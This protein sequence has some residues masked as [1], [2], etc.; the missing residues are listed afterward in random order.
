MHMYI[1][2]KLRNHPSIRKRISSLIHFVNISCEFK[3]Q[4][5][6]CRINPLCTVQ[7]CTCGLFCSDPSCAPVWTLG[8]HQSSHP[9]APALLEPDWT[10]WLKP[11]AHSLR[12]K[13]DRQRR[14]E[15]TKLLLVSIITLWWDPIWL[16]SGP[17]KNTPGDNY[18]GIMSGR[19]AF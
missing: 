16:L 12:I 13:P 11:A 17:E 3:N 19:Q 10:D 4:H 9:L 1:S 8:R 6:S 15:T 7:L 14:E 2:E 5:V 18:C